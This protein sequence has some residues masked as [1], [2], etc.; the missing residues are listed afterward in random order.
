MR[1]SLNLVKMVQL[2]TCVLVLVLL[3]TSLYL[4]KRVSEEFVWVRDNEMANNLANNLAQMWQDLEIDY[5][6]MKMARDWTQAEGDEPV[7][8]YVTLRKTQNGQ[9]YDECLVKVQRSQ[10]DEPLVVLEVV[11]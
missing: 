5:V 9:V 8:A 10:D 7:Y 1:K 4:Q 6:D 3:L 11:R 2:F